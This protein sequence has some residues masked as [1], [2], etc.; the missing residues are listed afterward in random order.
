MTMVQRATTT[1]ASM[2]NLKA[3]AERRVVRDCVTFL[4]ALNWLHRRG[5]TQRE[6]ELENSNTLIFSRGVSAVGPLRDDDRD[7]DYDSEEDEGE[8]LEKRRRRKQQSN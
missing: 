6:R 5:F 7:G 1:T 4:D 3:K 8:D 2:A